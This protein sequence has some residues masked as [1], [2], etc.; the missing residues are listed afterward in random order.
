MHAIEG[1]D[2]DVLRLL[3]S[4]LGFSIVASS[5]IVFQ[6]YLSEVGIL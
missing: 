6:S 4:R 5:V 2:T 1:E 3:C